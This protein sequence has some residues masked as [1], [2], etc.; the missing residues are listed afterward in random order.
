MK[1][2]AP[3]FIAL[4]IVA[5]VSTFGLAYKVI[6]EKQNLEPEVTGDFLH[7]LGAAFGPFDAGGFIAGMVNSI[8]NGAIRLSKAITLLLVYP[9]RVFIPGFTL[10]F[11]VGFFIFVVLA[12]S[13][14]LKLTTKFWELTHSTAT[15]TSVILLA[16]V[17][18][19]I[20]L[21]MLGVNVK[22]G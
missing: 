14:F 11:L 13:M 8:I 7:D 20:V 21:V 2:I 5:L 10:P 1:G 18:V 17:A 4:L 9:I 22:V 3:F 6:V 15:T 12:S 19:I 16:I